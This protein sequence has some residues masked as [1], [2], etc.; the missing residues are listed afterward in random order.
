ML[1]S[2]HNDSRIHSLQC[3][4]SIKLSLCERWPERLGYNR[5]KTEIRNEIFVHFSTPITGPVFCFVQSV[6]T[7]TCIVAF[8][9]LDCLTRLENILMIDDV[10][11]VR[12]KFF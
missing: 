8:A 10:S 6:I 5:R 12:Y 1:S 4:N 3:V 7:N 2:P 11:G 9:F